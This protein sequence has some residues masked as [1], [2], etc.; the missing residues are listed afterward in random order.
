MSS[1][2]PQVTI[3]N[4]EVRMISSATVDHE[5]RITVALPYEYASSNETHPVFYVLDANGVFGLVT[6]TIRI[7]Q[8]SGELPE[9]IVV[10]I[11]YPVD[12]FRETLDLRAR[13][14]TPTE[15]REWFDRDSERR[16]NAVYLGTG[17]AVNFLRFIRAELMPMVQAN[18]RVDPEDRAIGGGSFGGLFALYTL[19]HHPDTFKRYLIA[20]PSI[21]WDDTITFTYEANYAANNSDL[22]AKIFMSVGLLEEAEDSD[23]S[24]RMVTNMQKLARTLRGRGY[25][26]LELETCIF[27]DET[28]L[29]VIP[30]AISRGLRVIYG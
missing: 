30:A 12:D 27:E 11:G 10:G 19:Y 2:L 28:H 3:P 1:Q 29:S 13:D 26:S 23:D 20:S 9:L 24:S 15:N 4:T 8:L 17:G 22:P 21:W 25:D 18:Y 6:D 7:L 14:Y 16:P 5:F